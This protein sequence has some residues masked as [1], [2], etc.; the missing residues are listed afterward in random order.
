MIQL[1]LQPLIAFGNIPGIHTVPKQYDKL[2]PI[3]AIQP[4]LLGKNRLNE[5]CCFCKHRIAKLMIIQLI[6]AGK[7]IQIQNHHVEMLFLG[8]HHLQ[9]ILQLILVKLTA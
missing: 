7:L 9:G 3:I 5:L 8:N 4:C 2:I 6:D 1:L